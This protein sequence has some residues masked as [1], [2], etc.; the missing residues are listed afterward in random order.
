MEHDHPMIPERTQIAVIG[1][2]PGGSTVAGLLAEAGY[3]V[4]LI[5][6]GRDDRPQQIP[7]FS[8]QEIQ[9]KYRNGGLTIALGSPQISYIEGRCV[10][11]GSE[12]N[13]GLY[14]RAPAAILDHWARTFDVQGIRMED[15]RAHFEASE[16][17]GGVSSFEDIATPASLK[18]KEGA[19]L[20]GW[21]SVAVPRLVK[22]SSE[23]TSPSSSFVRQ[24]MTQTMVPRFLQAGGR[25]FSNL[26][27]SRLRR[28][29]RQWVIQAMHQGQ[30]PVRLTAEQ[31]FVCAGAIQTPALLQRSGM[32]SSV[33]KSF[34]LHPT[35]KVAAR[36]SDP[37]NDLQPSIPIHQIKAFHPR[38]SFGG[39]VSSRPFLALMLKHREPLAEMS[40]DEWRHWA[41]YYA[42]ITPTGHGQV[43]AI[44]GRKDPLVRYQLSSSDLGALA[45][46]LK[47]LCQVLLEA[48][49][50]KIH[51]TVEGVSA[52][53]SQ[54]DLDRIPPEMPRPKIELAT[55]HLFGTCPMG[56]RRDRCATDSFGSVHGQRGLYVADASVLCTALGVNPQGTIMAVARRNVLKFMGKI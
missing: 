42:M 2:G 51:P 43:T 8:T 21:A 48:G 20:L 5:E 22:R 27:V 36:F 53:Q 15:L 23:E 38:L 14:H 28:E 34:D 30:D 40:E 49:A 12:V 35:V 45:D 47:K 10:G 56:E 11:G 3:A 44:P 37:V 6:E 17:E 33:G 16:H 19:D 25:L 32:R 26:R 1:S 9:E 24:T 4:A 41:I 18:L 29:D 31:V 55:Y 46:G 13:S 54:K 7:S 52:I 50:Q 39:S